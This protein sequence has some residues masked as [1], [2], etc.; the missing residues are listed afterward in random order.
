MKSTYSVSSN[1]DEF[2][3]SFNQIDAQGYDL[4]DTKYANGVWFSAYDKNIGYADS[5]I[6]ESVASWSPS[7]AGFTERI[8]QKETQGYGLT[9]IEYADGYW[10]GVFSSSEV[11]SEYIVATTGVE[12][13]DKVKDLQNP[14][15]NSVLDYHLVDVEYANGYW[16]GV[17]NKTYGDSSYSSSADFDDFTGEIQ[18]QRSQG[19]ELTNVEYLDGAFLGIYSDELSGISTYSPTPHATTAQFTAEI[20]EQRSEGY[21][22]IN[23]ESIDG[24]WFGIYK[25]NIDGT[26]DI[27]TPSETLDPVQLTLDNIRDNM[28][29][30]TFD[31]S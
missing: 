21:H 10:F 11:D 16:V 25:E 19:L 6:N 27:I 5:R 9:D 28:I 8:K 17:L 3:R 12:F 22:L 31:Y 23:I 1:L 29:Y 14:E 13:D 18:R 4:I 7:F 15:S 26:D 20:E 24:E 30:S 2:D